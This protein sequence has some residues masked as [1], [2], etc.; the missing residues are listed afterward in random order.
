MFRTFEN[1]IFLLRIMAA[2][3]R[4]V[5]DEDKIKVFWRMAIAICRNHNVRVVNVITIL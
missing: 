4:L 2:H 1:H 5:C 3:K